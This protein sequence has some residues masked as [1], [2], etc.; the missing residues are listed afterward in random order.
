LIT[1]LKTH[2]T[3][4]SIP[5]L[6]HGLEQLD[7]WQFHQFHVQT[8]TLPH[9]ILPTTLCARTLDQQAN[10]WHY[11]DLLVHPTLL[12]QIVTAD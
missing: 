7:A 4:D 11:T 12:K 5:L 8:L 3:L 10:A 9:A 1:P 2:A 6:V